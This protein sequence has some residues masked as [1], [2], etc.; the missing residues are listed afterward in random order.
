MVDLTVKSD[1]YCKFHPGCNGYLKQMLHWIIAGGFVFLF[2]LFSLLSC[3]IDYLVQ[4]K[5]WEN[6]EFINLFENQYCQIDA[7]MILSVYF[8]S[9]YIYSMNSNIILA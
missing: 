7:G 2:W 6:L 8:L 9:L 4:K 5:N 1:A 3:Y